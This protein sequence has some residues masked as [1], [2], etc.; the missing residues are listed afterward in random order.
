MILCISTWAIYFSEEKLDTMKTA[1]KFSS[2]TG[3]LY[4]QAVDAFRFFLPKTAPEVGK[5]SKLYKFARSF[6]TSRVARERLY[7]TRDCIRIN[8]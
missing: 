4:L 2:S 8:K 7:E 6:P 3:F 5:T 1:E